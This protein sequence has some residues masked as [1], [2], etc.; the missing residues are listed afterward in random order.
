MAVSMSDAD[1]KSLI[2]KE[3]TKRLKAEFLVAQKHFDAA[4]IDIMNRRYVLSHIFA[5]RRL[6]GQTCVLKSVVPGY[7]ATQ[8]VIFPEDID[9]GLL[10]PT[11]TT[12][13]LDVNTIMFSMLQIMN[14]REDKRRDD[15]KKARVEERK[16]AETRENNRRVEDRKDR[17][18]ERNHEKEK[19]KD[20]RD[21]RRQEFKDNLK[22]QQD[23]EDRMLE[24]QKK[25][26]EDKETK[27]VTD[28]AK[29]EIRL[30]QANK[31]LWGQLYRMPNDI[32]NI[33]LYLNA[34][35]DLFTTSNI[36][37]DLRVTIMSSYLN[38]K[39][40][41]AFAM[42]S[43]QEKA[44]YLLFKEA[45]MRE[46]RITAGVCKDDFYGAV[47]QE[48]ENW[49]QFSTRLKILFKEY[50]KCRKITDSFDDLSA[51]MI[52]DKF[53]ETL[54]N[55][56]KFHVLD[57]EGE[58][59]LKV[60]AVAKLVYIYD[61]SR[62]QTK[63][64]HFA[65]ITQDLN[66][67]TYVHKGYQSR[68][69]SSPSVYQKNVSFEGQKNKSEDTGGCI[70]CHM[71]N[72]EV[73]DCRRLNSAQQHIKKARAEFLS[74]NEKTTYP[75]IN[76]LHTAGNKQAR[77]G[78]VKSTRSVTISDIDEDLDSD[79]V[80]RW[81][82]KDDCEEDSE[83]AVNR[84]Q[85]QEKCVFNKPSEHSESLPFAMN[86]P[87]PIVALTT[88]LQLDFGNGYVSAILDSGAEISVAKP[89]MLPANYLDNGSAKSEIHLKPAFG[90]SEH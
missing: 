75:S 70:L 78:I 72:H 30:A 14:D 80:D 16:D 10:T 74:R 62:S 1:L 6:A 27:R 42:M 31:T 83:K 53:K 69:G 24:A 84:I 90:K 36:D 59:W 71:K 56:Q 29:R 15:K 51:L 67:S 86:K 32:L 77:G 20:D 46:F 28:T 43:L 4:E 3:S 82:D 79:D 47:K 25:K 76:K 33:I 40:K 5:L 44:D 61:T 35:D 88:D 2:G 58:E 17:E 63:S 48:N 65:S 52:S 11:A 87:L 13:S 68:G 19:W 22:E 73:K 57:R 39:G 66:K 23:R 81:E 18:T 50:L 60:E 45:L 7:D 8:V 55:Q 54:S 64:T 49:L 38:D 89:S 26:D 37:L 85:L 21:E 34:M 12:A 9:P 41:R